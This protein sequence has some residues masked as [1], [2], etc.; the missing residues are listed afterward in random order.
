MVEQTPRKGLQNA[1]IT[2]KQKICE[3]G[4]SSSRTDQSMCS[5]CER[6]HCAASVSNILPLAQSAAAAAAAAAAAIAGEAE[7]AE[8]V[9]WW[10]ARTEQRFTCGVDIGLRCRHAC[11]IAAQV[12]QL[13]PE[14]KAL[15]SKYI[16]NPW[17][18]AP[19]FCILQAMPA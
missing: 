3:A 18:F 2:I 11:H 16:K 10:K 12:H 1:C 4:R 5:V 13:I 7:E 6:V 17:L 14:N 9:V 19:F 8:G 15:L